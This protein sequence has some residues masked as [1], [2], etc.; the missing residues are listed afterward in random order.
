[1]YENA[2]KHQD[3]EHATA[4]VGQVWPVVRACLILPI[5]KMFK[6]TFCHSAICS[7]LVCCAHVRE[8]RTGIAGL[9]WSAVTELKTP[10]MPQAVLVVSA[11]CGNNRH[12]VTGL[13]K[14]VV[15]PMLGWR[16]S[17]MPRQSRCNTPEYTPP[18][19]WVCK[20]QRWLP[21]CQSVDGF[22]KKIRRAKGALWIRY[23]QVGIDASIMS[24]WY[25]F[26]NLADLKENRAPCS[27]WDC[28]DNCQ[29]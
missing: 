6:S 5:Q 3:E 21:R 9:L 22:Q 19:H 18:P 23:R 2:S 12:T 20:A 13:G 28:H 24:K 7:L 14:F 17:F 11:S 1:M 4:W 10:R 27:I 15:L 29:R 25:I 8:S 26:E 16:K